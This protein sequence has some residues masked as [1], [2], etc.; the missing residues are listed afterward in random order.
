ML[1]I[2]FLF[3]NGA[4]RNVL[5]QKQVA[6]CALCLDSL[7]KTSLRSSHQVVSLRKVCVLFLCAN[8]KTMHEQHMVYANNG[9]CRLTL[10]FKPIGNVSSI[11]EDVQIVSSSSILNYNR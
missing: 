2:M 7:I 9:D 11:Y 8:V 4:R 3:E 6:F 10:F 5:K 1:E